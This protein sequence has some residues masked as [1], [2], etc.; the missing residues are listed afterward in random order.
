MYAYFEATRI[1]LPKALYIFLGKDQV[2]LPNHSFHCFDRVS[3]QGRIQHSTWH[4]WK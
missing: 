2:C 4:G 3:R 1:L